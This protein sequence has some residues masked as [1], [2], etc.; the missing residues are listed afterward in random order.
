MCDLHVGA[1]GTQADAVWSSLLQGLHFEVAQ[2][3]GCGWVSAYA[4]VCVSM[5]VCG[6]HIPFVCVCVALYV[7]GCA[8][9][10]CVYMFVCVCVYMF[11]CVCACVLLCLWLKCI[12]VHM[13]HGL[14]YVAEMCVYYIISVYAGCACRHVSVL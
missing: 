4:C 14:V 5:T 7:C 13:L 3:C 10:V 12:C 2:V 9:I 11:V 8:Y 1:T 6:W